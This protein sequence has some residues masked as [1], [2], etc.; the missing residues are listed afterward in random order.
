[1]VIDRITTGAL[2][3]EED[4]S[5]AARRQQSLTA[6]TLLTLCDFVQEDITT[7]DEIYQFIFPDELQLVNSVCREYY[8]AVQK[9]V[10]MMIF[11]AD[12]NDYSTF[13][14]SS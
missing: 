10:F 5:V 13:C 12:E 11:N 9:G 14:V 4:T 6:G 1:M 3:E 8:D 2:R 7:D